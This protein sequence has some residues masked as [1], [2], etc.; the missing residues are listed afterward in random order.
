[1]YNR[2]IDSLQGRLTNEFL[3]DNLFLSIEHDKLD[4]GNREFIAA[5]LRKSI[6][7]SKR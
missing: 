7:V 3:S 2:H 5:S 4:I 1:M 6:G